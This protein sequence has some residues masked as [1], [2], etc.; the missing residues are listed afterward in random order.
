MTY[1]LN[2]LR[3]KYTVFRLFSTEIH[4]YKEH[5]RLNGTCKKS[6]NTAKLEVSF[7]RF[8]AHAGFHSLQYKKPPQA[9]ISGESI[10][11]SHD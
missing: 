3:C 11:L 2:L 9:F 8:I 10:D 5:G 1:M 7:V 6:T 4:A